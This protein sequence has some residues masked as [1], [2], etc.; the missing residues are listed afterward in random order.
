MDGL[1]HAFISTCEMASLMH[2]IGNPPFGHFGELAINN[3]MRENATNVFKK[4]ITK[5]VYKSLNHKNKNKKI[6]SKIQN[7]IINFEG[8]AQGIRII[9]SLQALNLTYSQTASILKYTRVAYKKKPKSGDFIY[10]KKKPGFYF[11]EKEFVKK[12]SRELDMEKGY[13]FPL[14][15]I[16]E[17]ADDIAYGIADLEDAVDKG[18]LSL[19]KLYETISKEAEKY[20]ENGK[21]I[22]TLVKECFDRTKDDK[23]LGV[24]RFIVNLRTTLVN[25]MVKFAAKMYIK[26]HKEIFV[27]KY[28][29]ALL[30]GNNSKYAVALKVLKTITRKYVFK[31]SE[32]EILELKGNA[33]ITGLLDCYK[34]ILLLSGKDFLSII[35][36]EKNDFPIESRLF[37]RLSN[38]NIS[39]YMSI[40]ENLKKKVDKDK[41]KLLE[42]YYRARLILDFI[43]GM[44]DEY[45]LSEYQVLSA[46][47]S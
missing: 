22:S 7:D 4:S 12:L 45:A 24:N 25:D 34:P 27:G 2:D 8:N 32:V 19:K 37:H 13:R 18:I 6:I 11:S 44:T 9:H 42:W 38:K 20:D 36:E 15:Y 30:E 17:A 41:Y 46:I 39:T 21:Y 16:M 35:N 40:L 14:T 23:F 10:L 26:H 29:K 47:Q 31:N 1:E 43:S 5:K 3:W 33:A 28:N